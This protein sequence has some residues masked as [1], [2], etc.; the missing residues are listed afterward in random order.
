MFFKIAFWAVALMV[1]LKFLGIIAFS[2][3]AVFSPIITISAV[4]ALII[5][6][7]TMAYVGVGLF[8]LA[9]GERF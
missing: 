9:K 1:T 8:K 5:F 2:W 4:L 7:V 6:A 3:A